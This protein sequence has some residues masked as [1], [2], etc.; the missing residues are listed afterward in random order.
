MLVTTIWSFAVPVV[1]AINRNGRQKLGDYRRELVTYMD[2]SK[3][4]EGKDALI[5][6]NPTDFGES[7]EFLGN[8]W[9]SADI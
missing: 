8:V 6:G 1:V 3:L 9:G 2:T 7:E 4:M 5:L